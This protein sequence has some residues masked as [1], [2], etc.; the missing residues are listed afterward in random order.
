MT[1]K[2]SY[3]VCSGSTVGISE[4]LDSLLISSEYKLPISDILLEYV[5]GVVYNDDIYVDYDDIVGYLGSEV[6]KL[7]ECSDTSAKDCIETNSKF[8]KVLDTWVSH[9]N[10]DLQ[11]YYDAIESSYRYI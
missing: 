4:Q 9:V 1:Y 3:P 7:L 10:K 8:T 6:S 2:S 11:D 5:D